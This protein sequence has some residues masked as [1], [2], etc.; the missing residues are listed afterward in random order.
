MQRM[1]GHV[2]LNC[3]MD[4]NKYVGLIRVIQRYFSPSFRS[5][6]VIFG[7][8]NYLIVDMIYLRTGHFLCRGGEGKIYWKDQNFY[9]APP[10]GQV[11]S[12]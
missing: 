1:Y 7:Q 2:A 10:P 3:Q 11:I 9:K 5:K 8:Y 12:K 4:K 6:G